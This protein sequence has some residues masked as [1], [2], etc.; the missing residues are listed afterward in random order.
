MNQYC[1][2]RSIYNNVFLKHSPPKR[3]TIL[4]NDWQRSLTCLRFK[5]VSHKNNISAC[6][7]TRA[8]GK[9]KSRRHGCRERSADCANFLARNC[10]ACTIFFPA[11]VEPPRP[12]SPILRLGV[13]APATLP[14]ALSP[15]CAATAAGCPSTPFP[16]VL[17]LLVSFVFC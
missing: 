12:R 9:N 7:R 4:R 14:S 5:N 1:T 2:K 11:D 17:S 13:P 10:A 16:R 3:L 6:S 8:E 15:H